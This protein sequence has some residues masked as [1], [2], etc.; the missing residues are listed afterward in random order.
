MRLIPAAGVDEMAVSWSVDAVFGATLTHGRVPSAATRSF[1]IA[2]PCPIESYVV[3]DSVVHSGVQGKVAALPEVPNRA[4]SSIQGDLEQILD[5]RK[6]ERRIQKTEGPS[7]VPTEVEPLITLR[8]MSANKL[9]LWCHEHRL[10]GSDF[11]CEYHK[12]ASKGKL[13]G[14]KMDMSEFLEYMNRNCAE[15]RGKLKAPPPTEEPLHIFDHQGAPS[16]VEQA[17]GAWLLEGAPKGDSW[18]TTPDPESST[19]SNHSSTQLNEWREDVFQKEKEQPTAIQK[20]SLDDWLQQMDS[21][22]EVLLNQNPEMKKYAATLAAEEKSAMASAIP[23]AVDGVSKYQ[24][25]MAALCAE[26][27]ILA[28]EK[29]ES[30]RLES[31]GYY[32]ELPKGLSPTTAWDRSLGL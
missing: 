6:E 15:I 5:A 32:H 7:V 16:A 13:S 2:G 17:V 19:G 4:V 1:V 10:F 27:S 25:K 24:A 3:G 31:G 21:R 26:K 30:K 12:Q 14:A 8:G 23:R 11:A 18:R 28:L 20:H 22:Y 29:T 9:A